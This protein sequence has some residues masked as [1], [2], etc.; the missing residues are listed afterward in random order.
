MPVHT[1]RVIISAQSAAIHTAEQG[2][3][4]SDTGA[5]QRTTSGSIIFLADVP[6][7]SKSMFVIP[8]LRHVSA[9]RK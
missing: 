6:S 9:Q 7:G 5:A 8:A 2:M 1:D 4:R 3:K